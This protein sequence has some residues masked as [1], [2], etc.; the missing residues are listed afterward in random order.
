MDTIIVELLVERIRAYFFGYLSA[1][2]Q[3]IGSSPEFNQ[4]SGLITFAG[5]FNL[6]GIMD[7]PLGFYNPIYIA[8]GVSTNIFTAYRGL[9]SDFS[10]LG[11]IFIAFLIGFITQSIF[12][13]SDKIK[14]INTLPISMFYAFT[15]YS[16]LISIFHYNS[17]LFSWIII[18][19]PLIISKYGFVANN[20]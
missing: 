3:W 1:F 5:P 7:R 14:L 9:V 12:Q 13:N 2:S 11:S 4:N 8:N 20:R 10:I 17:I 16:P 15:L 19:F 6:I 18:L